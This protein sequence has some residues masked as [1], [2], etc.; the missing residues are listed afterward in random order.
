MYMYSFNMMIMFRFQD[1]QISAGR[2]KFFVNL[3]KK[4]KIDID[5][6]SA[7]M[8][9]NRIDDLD[10]MEQVII[11][12]KDNLSRVYQNPEHLSIAN[13]KQGHLSTANAKWGLS[14]VPLIP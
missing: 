8:D 10:K 1:R 12:H 5:K 14:R 11:I 13:K 9:Q 6:F 2:F 7:I 4:L 3:C